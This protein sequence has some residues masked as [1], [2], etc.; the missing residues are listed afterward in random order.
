M[1][2]KL[3]KKEAPII[4][5][6][7][8]ATDTSDLPNGLKELPASTR[9]VKLKASKYKFHHDGMTYYPHNDT[10][11][12]DINSPE[13]AFLRLQVEAGVLIVTEG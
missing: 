12:L 7:D 13:S 10:P 6:Y 3:E 5:D 9:P 11:V 4:P 8:A 1:A 2:P